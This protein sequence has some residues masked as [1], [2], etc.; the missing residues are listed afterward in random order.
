MNLS[1]FSFSKMGKPNISLTLL[2]AVIIII[3]LSFVLPK[4]KEKYLGDLFWTQKTFAPSKYNMVLMGD[5]RTYRGVSPMVMEEELPGIKILNFGYSDGGLNPTMF[6]AAEEKLDRTLSSNIIVLGI[7]ANT[8]TGYTQNNEQYLKELSRT[9]EEIFERLYLN[10]LL[11]WFSSVS[12][13]L[14]REQFKQTKK[15]SYYLNKYHQEGYVESVKFP[16]DTMEAIPLYINDFTNY[17][18][19]TKY[20]NQLYDQVREWTNLG[21]VVVG[22]RPPVSQPMQALEDSLGAYHEDQ[23]RERFVAFGGH[24]IEVKSSHYKTYDGSHLDQNSA[25]DFSYNLASEIKRI[26]AEQ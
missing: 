15:T 16:S 18:V 20:L 3:P 6:R 24:W 2:M 4:N 17:K 25:R 7:S 1:I 26:L 22:Y 11:Y 21:I 10:P 13:E 14:L 9:R 5:S 19:E 23:I 12:L 8:I